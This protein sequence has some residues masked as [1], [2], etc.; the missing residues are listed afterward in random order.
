MSV[1]NHRGTIGLDDQFLWLGP[2]HT[3]LPFDVTAFLHHGIDVT[4]GPR[5]MFGTVASRDS[6]QHF[7]QQV[8]TPTTQATQRI[9]PVEFA[10]L[11]HNI[12]VGYFNPR[13]GTANSVTI[14]YFH[15]VDFGEYSVV[16]F[17]G[18]QALYVPCSII[19]ISR[20][21]IVAVMSVRLFLIHGHN[22]DVVPSFSLQRHFQHYL[23]A[24]FRRVI[25]QNF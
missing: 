25:G 14:D 23:Y 18:M 17:Q 10:D 9:S 8:S 4:P 20:N 13:T 5:G 16:G 1:V 19:L 22:S 6:E 24:V 3:D 12:Q 15:L 7:A 11:F 21:R 2:D